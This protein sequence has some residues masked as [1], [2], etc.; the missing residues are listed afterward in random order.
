MS[1]DSTFRQRFTRLLMQTDFEPREI[2]VKIGD[3]IYLGS[4][5]QYGKFKKKKFIT[6]FDG[7]F[8]AE[9]TKPLYQLFFEQLRVKNPKIKKNKIDGYITSIF[10]GF[11][12]DNVFKEMAEYLRS[13][14]VRLTRRQYYDAC[15]DAQKEWKP[16]PNA[17]KVIEEIRNLGYSIT[18][19]SG[20]AQVALKMAANQIGVSKKYMD[21]VV[22]TEFEFDSFGRLKEIYPMLKEKKLVEKMRIVRK[23]KHVAI[24][25]DMYLDD[26]IT[27]GAALSIVVA[28]KSDRISGNEENIY[29]F[30]KS[31]RK[32]FPLLVKYIKK[33]EYSTVRC[34]NTP[35][36]KEKR[37]VELIQKIKQTEDEAEFFDSIEILNKELGIFNPFSSSDRIRLLINYKN[38]STEKKKTLKRDILTV[39]EEVPEYKNT[40]AFI[41]LLR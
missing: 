22:G 33:F 38:E 10:Q 3:E 16:N 32:N 23:G 1:G 31:I 29:V 24:T 35:E 37:I 15:R 39:L 40:E 2:H 34:Y 12:I 20:S 17:W 41:E 26:L 25:D 8:E 6:D 36:S 27:F 28:D 13:D 5:A 21:N 4:S 14:A 11:P 7:V 30:D 19:I 9:G 18:I